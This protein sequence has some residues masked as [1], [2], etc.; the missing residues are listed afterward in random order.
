MKENVHEA[1][2]IGENLIRRGYAVYIPHANIGWLY[3][4]IP[5]PTAIE[6]NHKFIKQCDI[7]V[8]GG[9]WKSSKGCKQEY[10][11]AKKYGLK[12]YFISKY[13]EII[14]EK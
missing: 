8:F 6:I 12:I 11:W 5:E 2:L 9:D 14:D 7:I 4:K 13:K 3:G 1:M 10:E